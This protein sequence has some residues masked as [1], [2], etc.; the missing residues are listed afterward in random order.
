LLEAVSAY[1]EEQ[2]LSLELYHNTFMP[3]QIELITL[4]DLGIAL[5]DIGENPRE[6]LAEDTVI[7]C[8]EFLNPEADAETEAPLKE[9]FTK[10]VDEASAHIADAKAQHDM[11][12]SFYS[13]AMDFEAV[14]DTGNQLFNKILALTTAK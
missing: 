8:G 6:T 12:E 13:K 2:G 10:L 4:P 7:L 3:Q 1:A 11:L 5:A 9:R 14:D